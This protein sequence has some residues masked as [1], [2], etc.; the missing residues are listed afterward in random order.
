MTLQFGIMPTYDEAA[1]ERARDLAVASA[2]SPGKL[3][4]KLGISRPAVAL[5]KIIPVKRVPDV[6]RV[7]GISRHVLRPDFFGPGPEPS[8][9]HRRRQTGMEA[10]A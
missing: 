3:A 4:K 6:E 5:W 7:T 8:P 2:G 1:M 10:T 9:S